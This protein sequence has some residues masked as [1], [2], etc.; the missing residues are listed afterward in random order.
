MRLILGPAGSGK[1]R[2][3]TEELKKTVESGKQAMLIVPEQSSFSFEKRLFFL[4]G[5]KASAQVTV[6]SFSRL[7]DDLL[8]EQGGGAKIRVNDASRVALVRRAV[9][10]AKDSIAYYRRN[11]NDVAFFGMAA[12]VIN[13]LKNAGVSPEQLQLFSETAPTAL[14][15]AKMSELSLIYASYE[16]LLEN[17]YQDG[18]DHLTAAAKAAKKSDMFK[19]KTVFIDG[20]TGFTEPEILLLGRMLDDADDVVVTMLGDTLNWDGSELFYPV[21]QNALRLVELARDLGRKANVLTLSKQGGVAGIA[22][23]ENFLSNKN[24]E[25]NTQGV[26]RIEAEDLYDEIERVAAEIVELVRS[27]GYRFSDIAVIARDIERYRAAI[28]RTFRL[29]DIPYFAD[30]TENQ[31]FSSA[32][33]FIKAALA[34]LDDL[35]PENLLALL[36]TSLTSLS[37]LEISSFENYVYVWNVDRDGLLLPFKNDPDGFSEEMRSHAVEKLAEAERVRETAV[38]WAAAFA[39]GAKHKKADRIIKEIY[40]LMERSGA[41]ETL[42]RR[43]EAK[44]AFSLLEQLYHILGDEEIAPEAILEIADVLFY[45][46][47]AGE[48]PEAIEQVQVGAA[49]RIRTNNPRAVFVVGLNEGV[50]PRQEFDLP[51]L[52]FSERDYLCEEGANLAR[53]F[54]NLVRMEELHFYNALTTADERLYISFPKTSVSGDL[55]EPTAKIAEYLALFSLPV[56]PTAND[57][58]A[59]IVNNKTAKRAYLEIEDLK[60]DIRASGLFDFC[61]TVDAAKERPHYQLRDEPL[62][63]KTV[64][65]SLYL[66]PSQ[67]E[68]FERCRFH[69]FLHYTTR[70]DPI[71]PAEMSPLQ[72]GNFIHAVMEYVFKKTNGDLKDSALYELHRLSD[73]AAGIYIDSILKE[74]VRASSRMQYQ[75][76]RLKSQARRLI[77]YLQKEQ[78]QSDFRPVDFE[79]SIGDA[80]DI[81]PRKIL[82]PDG[83]EI[84]VGGKIDRVDIADIDGARYVRV[85]DYKTGIKEF[86][87]DDVY[88]GLN[89]QMLL[90]LFSVT[91]NGG[92]RYG[93]TLPAGVL[94]MPSDP[95]LPRLDDGGAVGKTYRMDGLLLDDPKVAAAM[96]QEVAG[97]FIP[98]RA[99]KDGELSGAGKLADLAAMGRIRQHIDGTI[100]EMAASLR[101]GDIDALPTFKG[102]EAPCNYCP[103]I[104]VCRLDR[105]G[106]GREIQKGIGKLFS[107]GGDADD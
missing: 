106:E 80:G 71:Q 2:Y 12:G 41:V 102:D 76:T 36:K 95:R 23:M 86:S 103:Y 1:G 61:D 37:E 24:F 16:A 72:A 3:T 51:L 84:Y 43:G 94:Y 96:E 89:I 79:L 5:A 88:Y 6:K 64:P 4:L 101:E 13:E 77:G 63:E 33:V 91:E 67:V 42:N 60:I 62:L 92:A 17:R 75:I 22:A 32:A 27:E 93:D 52:S 45:E 87:L 98:V 85:V 15:K 99:K 97:V 53:S 57:R 28:R 20:F 73:E 105:I 107:E 81:P 74:G 8:R 48:I 68:T 35:S 14:S 46:T 55:L 10:A 30:W 56:Q 31:S 90:Y 38:E 100:A 49:D 26:Y 7:S 58:F 65:K 44:T 39:A 34:L 19:D 82:A 78:Q 21:R 47:S 9:A 11:K 25:V 66:S 29:Y 70:I 69:Y 104:A 50:F 18:A 40:K 54:D 59:K 83:T